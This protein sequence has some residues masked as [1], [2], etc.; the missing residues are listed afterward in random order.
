MRSCSVLW[1]KNKSGHNDS[2][3][4]F[5]KNLNLKQS[6]LFTTL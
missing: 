5:E 2:E 1:C 4:T 3:I 6:L